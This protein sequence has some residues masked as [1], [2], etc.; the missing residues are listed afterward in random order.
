MIRECN[1]SRYNPRDTS[2]YSN[3]DIMKPLVKF[4][5]NN[6]KKTRRRRGIKNKKTR[7]RRGGNGCDVDGIEWNNIQINTH[8]DVYN[9]TTIEGAD[10]DEVIPNIETTKYR[11]DRKTDNRLDV[12]QMVDMDG[13]M[14]ED[15]YGR[16]IDRRAIDNGY[17]KFFGPV[18]GGEEKRGETI[19]F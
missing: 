19:E 16:A 13:N 7:R 15:E 11:V 2:G 6:K 1:R 9:C 5:K 10:V 17:I 12:V 8:Y 4:M 18:D 14:A 3:N